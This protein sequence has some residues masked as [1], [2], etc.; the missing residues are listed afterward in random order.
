MRSLRKMFTSNRPPSVATVVS[1]DKSSIKVL[2]K[3]CNVQIYL[4]EIPE[5]NA[6]SKA[7]ESVKENG[8][9]MVLPSISCL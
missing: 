2:I 6:V 5:V 9:Q 7:R 4:R 3:V 1:G 8:R